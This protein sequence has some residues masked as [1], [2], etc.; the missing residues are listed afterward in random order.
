MGGCFNTVSGDYSAILGGS[1]NNDNGIP[2]TGMYGNGLVAT[3][4]VPGA[5]S[6]FWVD[7]LVAPSIPLVNALGYIG[8]PA[9]ALYITTAGG[10]GIQQVF[11][12]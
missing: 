9:G 10:F 3:A 12:K 6:S 1:G 11:V 7:T 4:A 8:L 5:P 2:F